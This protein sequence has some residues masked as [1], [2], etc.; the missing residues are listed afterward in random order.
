MR[1]LLSAMRRRSKASSATTTRSGIA[2]RASSHLDCWRRRRVCGLL[3][4]EQ[5]QR[6]SLARFCRRFAVADYAAATRWT[7]LRRGEYDPAK[8]DS[9]TL[10]RYGD[11]PIVRLG[12]SGAL[13]Q[14]PRRPRECHPVQSRRGHSASCVILWPA[15]APPPRPSGSVKGKEPCEFRQDSILSTLQSTKGKCPVCGERFAGVVTAS[16]NCVYSRDLPRA[17]MRSVCLF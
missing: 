14:H 13:I 3:C 17:R 2:Q 10:E 16:P 12:C 1:T 15:P 5:C 4:A 8:E 9:I 11:G 6:V 7:V